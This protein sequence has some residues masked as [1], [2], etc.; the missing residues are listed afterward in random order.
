[1]GK[2]ERLILIGLAM[3]IPAI[4][5]SP[6]VHVRLLGYVYPLRFE[7][8]L[9]LFLLPLWLIQSVRTKAKIKFGPF[10]PAMAIY[11]LACLASTIYGFFIRGS[12]KNPA[13]A[14]L[15]LLKIMEH[16]VIFLLVINIIKKKSHIRLCVIL[17]LLASIIVAI[18]G[19]FDRDSDLGCGHCTDL[20]NL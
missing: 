13:Y 2:L 12:V 19:F 8:I 9:L 18:Y 10:W 17:W 3:L 4:A 15:M 6:T 16:Y 11:L 5:F 1:M 14:V 7:Y 20:R